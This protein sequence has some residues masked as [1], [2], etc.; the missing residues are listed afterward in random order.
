MQ[1]VGVLPAGARAEPMTVKPDPSPETAAASQVLAGLRD[2]APAPRNPRHTGPA[3]LRPVP[4]GRGV[5]VCGPVRASRQGRRHIRSP[6]PVRSIGP[7]I[8]R[9]RR[10]PCSK[11]NPSPKSKR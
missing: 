11:G 9:V 5:F 7:I 2:G 4:A 3:P 1:P 10:S 8:T 6:G